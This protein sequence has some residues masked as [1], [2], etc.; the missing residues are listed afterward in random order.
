MTNN[1]LLEKALRICASCETPGQLRTASKWLDQALRLTNPIGEQGN[2]LR[3]VAC[4]M[5]LFRMQL[6][7]DINTNFAL[8]MNRDQWAELC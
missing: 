7:S 2:P 5:A 1:E 6:R 8:K 4:H 3:D